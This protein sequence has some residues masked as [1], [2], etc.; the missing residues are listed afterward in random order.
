MQLSSQEEYGLRCLLQVARHEAKGKE[1]LRIPEIA[2]SEGLSP[3]YT[4][5]LMRSLRQGGLVVSTR[6]ATGGYRLAKPAASVSVWE[7]LNVLGGTLFSEGFCEAHPGQLRD[8][9]HSTDC[10]VR[11]LWSWIGTALKTALSAVTLADLDGGEDATR[12]F[13]ARTPELV[14]FGA[15]VRREGGL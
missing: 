5:K 12:T 15:L 7:A 9:V 10:S 1:P 14:P 6:G 3:E 8:C 4:A 2:Q 11:S 13:L